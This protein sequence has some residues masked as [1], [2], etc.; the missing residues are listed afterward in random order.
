MEEINIQT[1]SNIAEELL[2]KIYPDTNPIEV[3]TDTLQ[4][5]IFKGD[6]YNQKNV[7]FELNDATVVL[8]EGFG[9]NGTV[10]GVTIVV[11]KDNPLKS[12]NTDD[13]IFVTPFVNITIHDLFK[14]KM[15][16]GVPITIKLPRKEVPLLYRT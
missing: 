7:S 8:P 13:L 2:E 6:R 9:E 4:L 5:K 15:K 16:K 11:R 12:A 10:K 1:I 14:K 3:I